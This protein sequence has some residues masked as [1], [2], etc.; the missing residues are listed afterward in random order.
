MNIIIFF[1]FVDNEHVQTI[2]NYDT[3]SAIIRQVALTTAAPPPLEVLSPNEKATVAAAKAEPAEPRS[4]RNRVCQEQVV[5][6]P[7]TKRS[8]SVTN[9][10]SEPVNILP[11]NTRSFRNAEFKQARYLLAP[12]SRFELCRAT[13]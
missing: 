10:S 2:Q 3:A 11:Q 7:A 8:K 5:D 4:K 12:M 1:F 13:S 9:T 6:A